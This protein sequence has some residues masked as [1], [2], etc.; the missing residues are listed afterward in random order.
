MPS[1]ASL[2][3][4]P[5]RHELSPAPSASELRISARW[6]PPHRHPEPASASR[7]LIVDLPTIEVAV[8]AYRD[9]ALDTRRNIYAR[10]SP[11]SSRRASKVGFESA[12]VSCTAFQQ[13]TGDF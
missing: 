13:V 1:C 2:P 10:S 5:K 9:A 12:R 11:S 3:H 8:G 7:R 6:W 4:V